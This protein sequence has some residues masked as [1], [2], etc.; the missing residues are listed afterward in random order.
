MTWLLCG[1]FLFNKTLLRRPNE[2][3]IVTCLLDQVAYFFFF[4]GVPV[5]KIQIKVF[6]IQIL[7]YM[8]VHIINML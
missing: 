4:Y 1:P 8:E 7:K 3:S 6:S 2:F 5:F